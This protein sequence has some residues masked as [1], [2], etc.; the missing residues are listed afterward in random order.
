[1]R[2]TVSL[3]PFSEQISHANTKDDCP[4]SDEPGGGCWRAFA[5]EIPSG[6]AVFRLQG[7]EDLRRQ[8]TRRRLD[9]A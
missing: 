3:V 6:D 8:L 1:M 5:W 4:F 9:S 7:R 2:P